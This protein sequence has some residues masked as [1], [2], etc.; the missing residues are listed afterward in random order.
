MANPAFSLSQAP[1]SLDEEVDYPDLS[2]DGVKDL[3]YG[4]LFQMKGLISKEVSA[5]AKWQI[6]EWVH[7][8]STDPCSFRA[9]CEI[10]GCD[11]E[12]VILCLHQTLE[13]HGIWIQRPKPLRRSY[14]KTVDLQSAG[15]DIE[16]RMEDLPQLIGRIDPQ[17][18]DMFAAAPSP[19][20]DVHG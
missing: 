6:W 12:E 13:H 4:L 2:V 9:A 5:L 14:W 1:S 7:S 11:P 10:E 3:H 8:E 16:P 15:V 19:Q 20:E 18:M 17:Q